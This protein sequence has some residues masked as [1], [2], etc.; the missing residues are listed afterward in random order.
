M[1]PKKPAGALSK[2]GGQAASGTKL[3]QPVASKSTPS[4]DKQYAEASKKLQADLAKLAIERWYDNELLNFKSNTNN[5]YIQT[6]QA[7]S[8]PTIE[9]KL[10][11]ASNLNGEIFY[12]F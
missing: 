11:K 9:G 7:T 1:A 12:F 5:Q 4:I 8:L 6:K 3:V 2:G 10:W